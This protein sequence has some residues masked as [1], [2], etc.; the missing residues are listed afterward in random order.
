MTLSKAIQWMENNDMIANPEKFK[1]IVLTKHDDQTAGSEFNFCGRTIYSSAEVDL[2]GVKLD[3]KPSFE[4]HISKMCKKAAGQLN[5][6]KRL[7]GCVNSY[8]TRKVFRI[9]SN[10]NCCPLTSLVF[11]NCKTAS[12]DGKNS[13][14][15]S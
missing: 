4:F 1:A 5:A 13:G 15:G 9:L 6:L 12:N 7:Q 11:F 8:N 10:F 2:L 3:T 14:K